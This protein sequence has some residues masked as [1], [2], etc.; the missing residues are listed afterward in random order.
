MSRVLIVDDNDG[1]REYLG[2]LLRSRGY[3]VDLAAD[4]LEALAKA[5]RSPPTL[6]VS[7]LLMPGMDGYSLLRQWRNDPELCGIRF[8][9]HTA[10][11][12]EDE[13]AQLAREFGADDFIVKPMEP[14]QLMARIAAVEAA[15]APMRAPPALAVQ[16]YVLEHYSH[17]LVRKL[18]ERSAQ[19]EK[20]NRELRRDNDARRRAEH[21]ARVSES[22]LRIIFDN[23]PECVK[24]VSTAG[25]LV[26]MNAAG[27]RLIEAED[28]DAIRGMRI[29]QIVRPE[30]RDAFL[31]LHLSACAGQ[32]GI[33]RFRIV[34][35]KG[36]ERWLESHATPL[37]DNEGAIESVLSVTR[38]ITDRLRAEASERRSHALLRAIADNVPVAL[39]VKDVDLRY[40]YFNR[41]AQDFVRVPIAQVLGRRAEDVLPDDTADAAGHH[42]REVLAGNAAVSWEQTYPVGAE[43][44]HFL[45]TKAPFRDADGDTAGI[46]TLA[47]DISDRKR[48]EVMLQ[49]SL[50][51]LAEHNRELQDFA[52]VASHDLQEPLRKIRI[53]ADAILDREAASLSSGAVDRVGRIQRAAQRMQGLIDDLLSYSRVVAGGQPFAMVDLATVCRE[54]VEDYGLDLR[55]DA[56]SVAV[57]PLPCIDA[58]AMQMRQLFANLIGNA[59]KFKR[60]DT[61]PRITIG[62]T[63]VEEAGRSLVRITFADN[64]IGFDPK[65]AERIFLPFQRLHR[66]DEH[67]GTGL[68]LSI[69]RRIVE[70]HRGGIVA[71]SAPGQGACFVIDLPL[72]QP[73]ARPSGITPPS[74]PAGDAPAAGSAT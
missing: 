44:R 38:D 11:Y 6:V 23:E 5:R 9:V 4:G 34:G 25:D 70:R 8:I 22:R 3:E 45:V 68:G 30:D 71:R 52:F 7:D 20:A 2:I 73:L 50:H 54:V 59:L 64:G 46:I 17:I 55:A 63:T 36:T 31:D 26:E 29:A 53:F 65:Y 42:D 58:D 15:G 72:R 51:E 16:T 40:V 66:H 33:A 60:A 56:A 61:A 41:R 47:Q 48:I 43:S 13:D 35:L 1:N 12:T 14:E 49:E 27:L 74:V 67:P 39:F 32:A 24:I 28:F 19:L 18:E 57:E 21:A 62:A 10:T 69:V 37:R